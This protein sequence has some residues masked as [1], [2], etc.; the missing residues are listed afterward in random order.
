MVI[1]V[2]RFLNPRR[3]AVLKKR[4][5]NF[6]QLYKSNRMGMLGLSVLLF[7]IFVAVFARYLAP[8]NPYEFS[9]DVNA[10]PSLKHP[11]GTNDVGQ[12]IFSELIYGTRISLLVGFLAAF[13][14][15]FIGGSIGI[16]AGYFKKL[17]GILM[18]VTDIFLVIPSFPLMILLAA[19]LGPSIGTVIFVIGIL[20][21]PYT[22]RVIRS[23]VLSLRER[24]FV[25]SA[26]VIG[27][28]DFYIL[29]AYIL[30]NVMPL[31]F[32][33]MVLNVSSAIVS[34][35]GL[36]F[37]GLSD[38]TYKSWGMILYFARIRGGFIRGAYWWWV[39]PG[40]CIAT[41]VLAFTLVGYAL[42]EVLN[43]RLRRR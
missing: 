18:R 14:S 9:P 28:S 37:L 2:K 6:W 35:A 36:A 4:F 10:P 40:L 41:V 7:F 43:P 38:V 12:D 31:L 21:W 1:K 15:T 42:D 25:E 32:A 11:L 39:P 3:T 20:S 33:N 26:K 5:K 19:Y 16:L 29:R 27:A 30:P 24:A 8:Y 17:D 22:A 23:Q 34:E 13:V